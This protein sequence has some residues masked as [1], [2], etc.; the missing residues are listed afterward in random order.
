MLSL[1]PYTFVSYKQFVDDANNDSYDHDSN[2]WIN[3]LEYI[4]YLEDLD[5]TLHR[6]NHLCP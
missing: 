4:D 6:G 2:D 3:E 1:K 5:D